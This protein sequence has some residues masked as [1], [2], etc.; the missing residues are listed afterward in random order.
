MTEMEKNFRDLE[1]LYKLGMLDAE[2]YAFQKKQLEEMA[3][4]EAQAQAP[5]GGTT[6]IQ[7]ETAPTVTQA[8]APTPQIPNDWVDA[9]SL[10]ELEDCFGP[11]PIPVTKPVNSLG[12][13]MVRVPGGSFQM[14]D[15]VGGGRDDER[16]V[17]TVT[18]SAF[19]I[20]KYEVTQALYESVT[21]NNPSKFKGG[22]LPV[23]QVSWY[24][25]IEFCNKLSER[26]GLKPAYAVN[27][28]NV[29]WNR[30]ANGYRL[31]TEAEW[32]YAAKGGNGSPG[33]YTYA[34]SNDVNS[35]AW[36]KDNSGNTTHAVG[37]KAPNGL[38]IYDMSG[39]VREWCWDWY[40][41]YSSD[42]QTDPVG[43]SSGSD[44]VAHG[45][46]W[47]FSAG[48]V[49]SANRDYLNPNVRNHGL[50]FRLARP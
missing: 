14:G 45:G 28:E 50:G 5:T 4:E 37:T 22:N 26:E 31:P 41:K 9:G 13:E 25:V 32:E 44:R 40:G 2:G 12:Y 36:Y 21:G 19:S 43:A 15:T 33:N 24:D 34:G 8:P 11:P 39:N 16:P 7:Q 30:N 10:P 35:V 23:E 47:L 17:H 42:A 29:E 6:P 48:S 27:G 46:T 18:L 1:E 38:G 3:R 20:G 49:R